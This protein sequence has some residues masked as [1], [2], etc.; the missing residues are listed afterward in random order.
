MNDWFR[1]LR[2][3]IMTDENR[4]G[5][6]TCFG[7]TF[8]ITNPILNDLGLNPPLR[9]ERPANNRHSMA[10][11]NPNVTEYR[12]KK[13]TLFISLTSIIPKWLFLK[14][15]VLIVQTVVVLSFCWYHWR[16][17][18]LSVVSYDRSIAFSK[19]SS[20]QSG[21]ECFLFKF[22]VSSRSLRSFLRLT[23]T[24]ILPSVVLSVTHLRR[25]FLRKMRPIHLAFFF[26]VRGIFFFALTL[27]NIS[28]RGIFCLLVR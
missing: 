20:P 19:A 28:L 11:I 7:A 14:K 27:C 21:I 15:S 9:G 13:M 12:E 2:G 23:I 22:P 24:Y 10:W 1:S 16:E 26:I 5:R 6:E 4:N 3:V 8:S 18:F 25:Q 17:T